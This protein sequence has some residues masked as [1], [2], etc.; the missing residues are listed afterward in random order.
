MVELGAMM[1]AYVFAM[2]GIKPSIRNVIY[3]KGREYRGISCGV[4]DGYMSFR[5]PCYEASVFTVTVLF[6]NQ[7]C[8]LLI[9]TN[10]LV[11][12]CEQPKRTFTPL[13]WRLK[14]SLAPGAVCSASKSYG[15][16]SH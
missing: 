5:I 6:S 13:F 14:P 16:L 15:S 9:G 4:F 11:R 1:I 7:Y 2:L 3:K 8:W 12:V 10:Q